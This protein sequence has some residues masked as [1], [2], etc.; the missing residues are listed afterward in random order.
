MWV[1]L[2]DQF[3]PER[4]ACISVF[5]QGFLYGDG[6]FETLRVHGRRVKFLD[7]HLTRLRESCHLITLHLPNPEPNWE[8]HLQELC[9]R[10]SLLE[11]TIR[12]TVTRGKASTGFGTHGTPVPTIVMFA[13]PL[14]LLTSEQQ[15]QGVDIV[16]TDIRRQ[17]PQALPSHMKSL[18]YL[19]N[20]LAKQEA[21]TKH[22]FDGLM[23]NANNHVAECTTSNVF[24]VTHLHLCTPSIAC[25]ILP[26]IT[27]KIV[28]QLAHN[29][30]IQ[31]Q[32]GQYEREEMYQATECFL[33]NTGLGVLPVKTID[34]HRMR[35]SYGSDSITHRLRNAYAE[36]LNIVE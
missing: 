7:D 28:L 14:S 12:I 16:T 36:Y 30:G 3:V 26:G 23:L 6:V 27:R 34:S 24:F 17:S 20:I 31:I 10:N 33:T 18:N 32:E 35:P 8:A 21:A 22:A 5:D 11:A 9:E 4:E 2:N 25:G 13:R 15:E 29:E 1:F 19:N